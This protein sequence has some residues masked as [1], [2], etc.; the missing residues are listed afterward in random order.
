MEVVLPAP[1]WK[2]PGNRGFNNTKFLAV[3]QFA[4]ALLKHCFSCKSYH[5][6]LHRY[7]V[8]MTEAQQHEIRV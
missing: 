5:A 6:L 1:E 8:H 2:F 4:S 7:F 3:D